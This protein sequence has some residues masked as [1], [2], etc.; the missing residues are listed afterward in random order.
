L[1]L[2]PELEN[3]T[4]NI[5]TLAGNIL[6]GSDWKLG[7]DNSLLIQTKEE[8]L[9]EIILNRSLTVKNMKNNAESITI[10]SGKKIYGFYTPIVKTFI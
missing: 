4:G 2:D 5:T 1:E 8:P 7:K 3:N 6:E 9:Y 10:A